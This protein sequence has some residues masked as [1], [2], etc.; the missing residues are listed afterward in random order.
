MSNKHVNH[1][2]GLHTMNITRPKSTP[3][4]RKNK[5]Q[6]KIRKAP[7]LAALHEARY[8]KTVV[9][10]KA[11]PRTRKPALKAEKKAAKKVIKKAAIQKS[12]GRTNTAATKTPRKTKAPKAE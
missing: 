4:K 1:Q 10:T 6:A 12:Q 8:G 5:A 2:H 7:L 9:T 3:T 11:A